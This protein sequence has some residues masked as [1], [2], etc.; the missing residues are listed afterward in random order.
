V[1]SERGRLS[2]TAVELC[3]NIAHGLGSNFRPLVP[4]IVPTLLD[5][6]RRPNK[7]VLA[8]AQACLMDFVCMTH[9]S[10]I[11]KHLRA[12]ARD[13]SVQLRKVCAD[14]TLK[15]VQ[16]WG[17]DEV[18]KRVED[19]EDI[20]KAT[21]RDA[22]PDVRKVAKEIY[23]FYSTKWPERLREYV[24]LFAIFLTSL[25]TVAQL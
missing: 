8:R 3:S 5:L 6:C 17:V 15:A 14:A 1:L 7:V 24:R 11:L 13:K 2:G 20:I 19:V 22:G 21:G 25:T 18:G 4:I 23:E 9:C 12:V 16:K 10:D